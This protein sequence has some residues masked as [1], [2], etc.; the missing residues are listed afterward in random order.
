MAIKYQPDVG[1]ILLCGFDGQEPEMTKKRP[2]VVLA[3]ISPRLCIVV[4]LS[5]T[6]PDTQQPWHY[7]VNTPNP[8]PAPYDSRRHWLKG[9]MVCAVGFKRLS[10]PC[11]G[12]DRDGNR[13]YVKIRLNCEEMREVRRC[14]SAA[15][16]ITPL[17]FDEN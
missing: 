6:A 17:D 10:M 14:V 4:P 9:D 11:K 3:S 5:T 7:L 1:S 16:G 2:V 8:L 15:I 13:L 12:K